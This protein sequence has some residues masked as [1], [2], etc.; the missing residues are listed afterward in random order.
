M[1]LQLPDNY[2]SSTTRSLI[3]NAAIVSKDDYKCLVC[4]FLFGAAD[5]HNM[6]VPYSGNNRTQYEIAR[7]TGVRIEKSEIENSILNPNP[8]WGLHPQLPFLYD[9]WNAGRLAIVRDVGVLNKPTTKA[10]YLANADGTYVPLSLFAH[11][12]QQQAWQAALPFAEPT[13]TGWFGRASNLIDDYFNDLAKIESSSISV[14]G[15]RLQ[16]FSYIPKK[17]VL[18][19]PTVL[20]SGSSS[21]SNQSSFESARDNFYHK[22]SS[23]LSPVGYPASPI[24]LIFD[25]FSSVF[26]SS[27]QSQTD[28]NL[29]G[30]GWPIDSPIEAIFAAAQAE[31]STLTIT[32]PG[33]GTPTVQ[34]ERTL[35]NHYFLNAVKN[36][37]KII[38]SRGDISGIGFNQTRQMIFS[39]VG[40]WDNHSNLRYN[41]DAL[42]RSLDICI[43]ALRDAI[44]EMG[45]TQNVTIFTESEFART[46]RSNGNYGTDHA[47]S[48]HSFVLG[49]AV[50]S[51]LYGP[52]PDYTLAGQ[53]DISTLGRFI[54]HYSIEQYYASMLQWMDIPENLI[55]LI[56]PSLPLF[57]PQN[58]GFL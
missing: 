48:G 15:N 1:T 29:H 45:L 10:Q 17:S 3:E 8:G 57:S 16:N 18:Y 41:Q 40:G 51:G 28:T 44:D 47:W 20:A 19:P 50:N 22:N 14:F 24:N 4:I 35:P 56:L 11:N 7:P 38:Y 5:S 34:T 43:K 9:E 32:V 55:S 21:G 33:L 39:G 58:I 2:S 27:V 53:L 13:A 25:A 52:E 31:I 46:F 23:E 12:I 37:A 36:I 54:P 26:K 30:A 42:L 49:G 6:L